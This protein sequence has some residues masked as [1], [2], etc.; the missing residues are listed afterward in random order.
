[1]AGCED[2]ISAVE[3]TT[4][5]LEAASITE[6]VES[7]SATL[8]TP[9]FQ[10][11]KT[12]TGVIDESNASLASREASWDAS[13]AQFTLDA[14]TAIAAAGYKI[15]GDFADVTKVAITAPNQVYTS[16][17]IL[18]L[19]DAVWRYTGVIPYT[20]TE[21][22]P[23]G[24][25]WQAVAIGELKAIARSLNIPD[26]DIMY[27]T[28]GL[29]I[30][31]NITHIYVPD[32]QKTY[33]VP[34]DAKGE[35]IVSVINSEL[36]TNVG[37]YSLLLA[38]PNSCVVST[39]SDLLAFDFAV[40]VIVTTQGYYDGWAGLTYSSKSERVIK[41]T[42]QA[43][44][45]GDVV[46]GF[47]NITTANGNIAVLQPINNT[48]DLAQCGVIYGDVTSQRD[49]HQAALNF[50]SGR[51]E[52]TVSGVC[53]IHAVQQFDPNGDD[54]FIGVTIPSNIII[55]FLNNGQIR[56]LPN[57]FVGYYI[58][59][60]YLAENVKV[61]DAV[62]IGD[63]VDHTGTTGEWGHGHNLDN[64]TNIEL[65]R[66]VT[67]NMWGDGIYI[68]H[69]SKS[70]VNKITRQVTVNDA[71]TDNVRR[72][73]ISVAGGIGVYINN[74]VTKNTAGT[75][76]Q[77]GIDIEPEGKIDSLVQPILQQCVINNP[78]SYN[79]AKSGIHVALISS[80][81]T[82]VVDVTINNPV[83]NASQDSITVHGYLEDLDCAVVINNPVS[84]NAR[85]RGIAAGWI[86]KG[87]LVISNPKV[88]NCSAASTSPNPAFFSAIAAWGYSGNLTVPPRNISIVDVEAYETRVIKQ[89][90]YWLYGGDT[91]GSAYLEH[92]NCNF[93]LK[94]SNTKNGVDAFMIAG[95][96]LD[97]TLTTPSK[98]VRNGTTRAD[99]FGMASRID[100][101]PNTAITVFVG[102]NLL[103]ELNIGT[104]NAETVTLTT[105]DG[106]TIYIEGLGNRTSVQTA[107]GGKYT[108]IPFSAKSLVISGDVW[109]PN[110]THK[111]VTL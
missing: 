54:F 36:K 33:L 49:A 83:D 30:P 105:T 5:K 21:S 68:G 7:T 79:C 2:L 71:F 76:P 25:D 10:I 107:V 42:S 22:T 12:L 53:W 14:A 19:E 59:D 84:L 86:C 35:D 55:R 46:D 69:R 40:G 96:T 89:S 108:L 94:A 62:L 100:I 48:I 51:C 58:Y 61:Y 109:M 64:V 3:L 57:N 85:W 111:W 1:M 101:V 74:P 29:P 20:P 98:V 43:Y 82:G 104:F 52:L 77:A 80:N 60:Y 15:I 78:V 26:A 70:G 8:T 72:N 73:G 34:S 23:L 66:P 81:L 106:W 9:Q 110:G 93:S 47:A 38:F 56:L 27:G 75:D 37:I 90:E 32:Q 41:T 6:F 91:S 102:Q 50:A 18:N 92:E 31:L 39:V 65:H 87:K 63:R 95:L 44:A 67:F 88:H 45:D 99:R 16:T 17:S 13:Q 97:S 28:D 24:N 11:K 103:T 4:A